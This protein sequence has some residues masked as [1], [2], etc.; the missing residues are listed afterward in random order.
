MKTDVV[1]IGA[2]PTGLSLACQFVRYGIDFIIVEK[3]ATVTPYSKALG[4]HAR[5][6]EVYEQI[7][8]AA[9]AVSQGAVAGKVRLVVDGV[10]DGVVGAEVLC[11]L[12]VAGAAF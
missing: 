5:T 8:L 7:D 1:I 12:Q 4:V 11:L 10:V 3:N 6:L 9:A 2:G